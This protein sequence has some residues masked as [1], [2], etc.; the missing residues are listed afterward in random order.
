MLNF[1]AIICSIIYIFL[2]SVLAIVRYN[3]IKRIDLSL[4]MIVSMMLING[5]LFAFCLLST[6]KGYNS[7]F[8]TLYFYS[9]TVID[10]II[11]FL[12]NFVFVLIAIF[13]LTILENSLKSKSPNLSLSSNIYPLE[14][15]KH[16]S[17]AWILLFVSVVLYTLY[18]DVYGGYL[19]YL[20]YSGA[21]RSGIIEVYNRFSFFN[22]M[23]SLA[24]ISAFIFYSLLLDGKH[25]RTRMNYIGFIFS[26]L[27]SCYVLYATL[28][29][30]TIL[31]FFAVILLS[32]IIIK[33]KNTKKLVL[34]IVILG[35][36]AI[37]LVY[38][39]SI[40]LNRA[41]STDGFIKIITET[42]SFPFVNFIHQIN[43]YGMGSKAYFRFFQDILY[44]PLFLLPSR[45]WTMLGIK[46]ASSM[47]TFYFFGAFKGEGDVFG[48]MPLDI[49]T[50]GYIQLGFFGIIVMAVF[51][52]LYIYILNRF[53]NR[54][55]IPTVKITLG[56]YL[57]LNFVF[58]TI[59]YG[60]TANI[61]PRLFSLL[62]YAAVYYFVNKNYRRRYNDT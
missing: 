16:S 5:I 37:P 27:Y 49:L 36:G 40:L 59:L 54:I 9:F 2:L 33:S 3:K 45:F 15:K 1:V 4:V 14:V 50:F 31:I 56:I 32:T 38:Y 8:Y 60:D 42:F 53:L 24:F 6:F 46:S 28:G 44:I 26:F 22:S 19:G 47:H 23:G 39:V 25:K 17:S 20:N 62:C 21:I 61:M 35:L 12:M 51:F 58:R 13:S 29:R 41:P 30:L 48:E 34:S 52:G 7:E 57:A 43:D 11:Y 55:N 10:V 18:L